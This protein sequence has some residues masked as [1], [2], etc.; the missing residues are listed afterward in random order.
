MGWEQ[1]GQ[2]GVV[3]FNR[4]EV[5]NAMTMGMYHDLAQVCRELDTGGGGVR[6]LL[7]ISSD[8]NA[9]VSGTDISEFKAFSTPEDALAY[10]ETVGRCL[11]VLERCAIPVI[12]AI[13]GACTGGGM[14]IAVCSDIRIAQANIKFGVPIARTVGNC[15][16]VESIDR[17]VRLLGVARVK[18]LVMTAEFGNADKAMAWGLVSEVLA[19]WAALVNRAHELAA[20]VAENA[21]ITLSVTK[22]AVRR[23]AKVPLPEGGDLIRRAYMSRDFREGVDSFLNKRKPRWTGG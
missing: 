15:L 2:V 14:G 21:P 7:L 8:Q 13:S 3:T 5:R 16:S 22:E 19:D 18:E 23:L 17:F 9:F 11:T 4:P 10:E 12:S 20:S 6:V 1:R